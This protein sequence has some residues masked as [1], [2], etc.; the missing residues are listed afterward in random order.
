VPAWGGGEA[1][2]HRPLVPKGTRDASLA[3]E[4]RARGPG[5]HGATVGATASFM[6]R[7]RADAS[8]RLQLSATDGAAFYVRLSGPA[9]LAGEVEPMG[10][11]G[12]GVAWR[13]SYTPWDAG[14]YLLELILE[15]EPNSEELKPWT[16]ADN[17]SIRH[18]M[19]GQT[20]TTGTPGRTPP[21]CT[22]TRYAARHQAPRG[23]PGPGLESSGLGVR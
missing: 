3:C 4:L 23:R 19:S 13:V 1:E 18:L 2:A 20:L 22:G 17:R 7:L 8:K 6:V 11:P 9:L 15:C 5:R 14:R 10:L 21:S 12:G 16:V